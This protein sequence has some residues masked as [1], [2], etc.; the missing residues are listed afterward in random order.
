MYYTIQNQKLRE[1]APEV[2][3]NSA[4]GVAVFSEKEWAE[5]LEQKSGFLTELYRDKV[6]FCKLE[7]H[8]SYLYATF[9][10]PIKG[11]EKKQ[12][13]FFLYILKERLIFIDGESF[14]E[15]LTSKIIKKSLEREYLSEYTAGRFL[16]S[17]IGKRHCKRRRICLKR[18]NGKIS[19]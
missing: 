17:R 3:E 12:H 5:Q 15:E 16:F 19:L 13:S 10:I 4:S 2:W 8:S 18:R 11:K 9:R 1:A 6:F 7:N 14:A